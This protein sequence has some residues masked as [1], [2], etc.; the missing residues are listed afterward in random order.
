LNDFLLVFEVFLV[1]VTY[2]FA[3]HNSVVISSSDFSILD[4]IM[5]IF[6]Y[7]IGKTFFFFLKFHIIYIMFRMVM[8]NDISD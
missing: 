8:D 2:T 7:L 4:I 1:V 3:Y 6:K 5:F